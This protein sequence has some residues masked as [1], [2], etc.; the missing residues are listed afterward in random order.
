MTADRMEML[1]AATNAPTG[2]PLHSFGEWR[3]LKAICK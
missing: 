1:E 3:A 2:E